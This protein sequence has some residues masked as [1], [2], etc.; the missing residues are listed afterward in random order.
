MTATQLVLLA[1]VLLVWWAIHSGLLK[2]MV[3]AWV[4][5]WVLG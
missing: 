1:V 4:L 3:V 2:W 5:N